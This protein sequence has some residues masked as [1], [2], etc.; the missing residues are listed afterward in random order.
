MP[1]VTAGQVWNTY[2]DNTPKTLKMGLGTL[3]K[4][5]VR[6]IKQPASNIALRN[7]T[8]FSAKYG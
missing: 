8:G 6:G 4:M 3:V 2:I 1:R 7:I 5:W